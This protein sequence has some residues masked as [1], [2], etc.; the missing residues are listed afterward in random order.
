MIVSGAIYVVG[1]IG[2]EMMGAG[3]YTLE[4]QM[5]I[6]Y[7]LST[8]LEEMMEMTGLIVFIYALTEY[9]QNHWN[10]AVQRKGH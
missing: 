9:I 8:H 1:A 10:I 5:S 6:E 3:F 7:K 4:G 2:V